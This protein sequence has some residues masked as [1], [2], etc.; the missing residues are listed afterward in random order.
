MPTLAL[1]TIQAGPI[2]TKATIFRPRSNCCNTPARFS[3]QAATNGPTVLP[4]AIS[5]ADG[6][7]RSP[8]VEVM[9]KAAR[10]MPGQQENP[11]IS[12]PASAMPLD[13]QNNVILEP[14]Y[15]ILS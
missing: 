8:V 7:A 9:A 4:V 3:N 14:I 1:I 13:G 2:T 12:R 6:K 11:Q 5:A 15:G 10:K